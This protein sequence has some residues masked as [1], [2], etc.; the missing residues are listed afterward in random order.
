VLAAR[1]IDLRLEDDDGTKQSWDI[2]IWESNLLLLLERLRRDVEGMTPY[3][4]SLAFT[5]HYTT[6]ALGNDVLRVTAQIDVE[7]AR[8]AAVSA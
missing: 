8:D 6:D 3:W 7:E 1:Y 5:R 4:E 2:G